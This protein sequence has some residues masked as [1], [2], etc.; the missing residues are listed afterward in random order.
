MA[1]ACP[2]P[3]SQGAEMV[4]LSGARCPWA[5]GRAPAGR[6]DCMKSTQKFYTGGS[7]TPTLW[8]DQKDIHL[9]LYWSE[10]GGVGRSSFRP[11]DPPLP[12][13][14]FVIGF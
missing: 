3:V 9:S 5:R 4:Q 2:R 11:L 12:V 14:H 8:C 7:P 13:I 6:G 1:G 10:G